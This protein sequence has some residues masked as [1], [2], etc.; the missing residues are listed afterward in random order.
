MECFQTAERCATD[1]LARNGVRWV[2]K[3]TMER[4]GNGVL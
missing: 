1:I 3:Y 4:K 2:K